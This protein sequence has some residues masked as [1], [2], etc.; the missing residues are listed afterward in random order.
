MGIYVKKKKFNIFKFLFIF[1]F[2]ILFL[3]TFY[4]YFEKSNFNLSNISNKQFEEVSNLITE[5]HLSSY[6]KKEDVNFLVKYSSKFTSSFF[7]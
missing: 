4:I 2:V 3:L 1:L 6:L 5:S 7:K